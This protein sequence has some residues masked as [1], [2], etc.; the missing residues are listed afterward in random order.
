MAR[1][2]RISADV[3]DWKKITKK[4]FEKLQLRTGTI[5]DVKRHPNLVGAYVLYVDMP[6]A[7]E[8]FQI[9]AS[10]EDS[11]TL[12]QLLGKQV[13]VVCNIKHEWVAG[14]E[15]QGM[16]LVATDGEKP[17]LISPNKKVPPGS[18]VSGIMNGYYHHHNE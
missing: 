9:V 1:K 8:A 17:V 7:D 4:T 6:V 3:G 16:I 2:K 14:V 5:A 13:I 15:S 18:R 12:N 10:L 11:Y